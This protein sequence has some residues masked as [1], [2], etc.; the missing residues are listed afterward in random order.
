LQARPLIPIA[1][2]GDLALRAVNVS[3]PSEDFNVMRAAHLTPPRVRVTRGPAKGA[4]LILAAAQ[5][6][7]LYDLILTEDEITLPVPVIEVR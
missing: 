1:F 7:R 6:L 3:A 5:G 4:L 2:S